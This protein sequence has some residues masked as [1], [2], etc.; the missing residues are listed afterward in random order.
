MKKI[1]LGLFLAASFAV[2][3]ATVSTVFTNSN[4]NAVITG[5]IS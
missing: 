2:Y 1:F 4:T 5:Y 3:G